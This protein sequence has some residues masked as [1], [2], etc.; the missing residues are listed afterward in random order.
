MHEDVIA[1][2]AIDDFYIP[3]RE[4]KTDDEGPSKEEQQSDED[5]MLLPQNLRAQPGSF[6]LFPS[7]PKNV[8]L[9]H[10]SSSQLQESKE[11]RTEKAEQKEPTREEER[12]RN[13][14]AFFLCSYYQLLPAEG[15]P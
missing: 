11:E 4:A 2:I 7:S 3:E 14:R 15:T 1:L 5:P 8:C 13:A 12:R 6:M 9:P 10:P